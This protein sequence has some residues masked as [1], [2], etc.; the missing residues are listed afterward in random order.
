MPSRG[1][2]S[3]QGIHP[4]LLDS[5]VT[6]LGPAP[7]AKI[8]PTPDIEEHRVQLIAYREKVVALLEILESTL[9]APDAKPITSAGEPF[10][11]VRQ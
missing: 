1:F 7:K 9:K 8:G 6:L 5:L 10:W 11:S 4:S 2:R 3:L